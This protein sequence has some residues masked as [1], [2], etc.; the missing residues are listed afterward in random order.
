MCP[1]LRACAPFA[2]GLRVA[3]RGNIAAKCRGT[4]I[5]AHS[6]AGAASTAA[7]A[8]APTAAAALRELYATPERTS[9]FIVENIKCRQADVRNL[10]FTKSD[11]MTH[12]GFRRQHIRRRPA[13]RRCSAGQRQRQSGGP[14]HRY[15]FTLAPSARSLFCAQH[16]RVSRALD[17]PRHPCCCRSNNALT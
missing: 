16:G 2:R 10:L 5:G 14:Q 12:S 15:G 8:T 3:R 13:D 4:R 9:I 7:T 11:C 17:K 6:T 1:R